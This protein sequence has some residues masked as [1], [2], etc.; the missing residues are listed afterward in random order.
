M[1]EIVLYIVFFFLF[2]IFFQWLL[3]KL[4]RNHNQGDSAL[5]VGTSVII[6]I[7]VLGLTS[8]NINYYAAILGF[9]VDDIVGEKSGWH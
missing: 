8:K 5:W 4:R 9:I 6:C 2:T 3:H 1:F 7:C